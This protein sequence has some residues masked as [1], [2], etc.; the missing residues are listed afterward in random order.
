MQTSLNRCS[1]GL[2]LIIVL[3]PLLLLFICYEAIKSNK[4]GLLLFMLVVLLGYVV[5]IVSFFRS[6]LTKVIFDTDTRMMV[7]YSLFCIRKEISLL[8]IKDW[9]GRTSS[10]TSYNKSSRTWT[11]SYTH[12]VTVYTKDGASHQFDV[13]SHPQLKEF[14]IKLSNALETCGIKV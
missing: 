2:I 7:Y 3:P 4:L 6:S 1:G 8:D 11:K 14:D 13:N 12:T 9:D 10:T 5:C